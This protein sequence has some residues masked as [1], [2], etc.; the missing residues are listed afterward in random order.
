MLKKGKAMAKF[1]I[2]L[3]LL[4]RFEGGFVQD[5]DDPGGTTNKGITFET[6]TQCAKRLL[7]TDATLSTLRAFP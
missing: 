3:P 5:P 7:G 4:L 6:F 2:F 1:E